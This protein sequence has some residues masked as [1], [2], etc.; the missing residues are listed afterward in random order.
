MHID[1]VYFFGATRFQFPQ[2]L[3]AVMK[4]SGIFE[5]IFVNQIQVVGYLH[6]WTPNVKIGGSFVYWNDNDVT[7]NTG[8]VQPLPRAGTGVDGSKVIHAANVYRPGEI[9]PLISKDRISELY[10]IGDDKWV[11]REMENAKTVLRN[12]TTDDLRISIVYRGRCFENEEKA[13][14]FK[15]NL[16]NHEN[17]LELDDI[18]D[19]LLQNLVDMNKIT[20]ASANSMSRFEIAETLLKNYVKY[21]KSPT[22]RSQFPLNYCIASVKYPFLK[23][24]LK[25]FCQ[26]L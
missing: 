8:T 14:F 11:V 25:P 12:Y 19:R 20:Q 13:K 26:G 24:I 3:L 1:G 17:A 7:R 21:P 10:Y 9:P 15:D 2:W 16:H 18:L 23:S 4:F 5:H 22:M 6:R